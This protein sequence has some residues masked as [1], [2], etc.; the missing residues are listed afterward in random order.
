MPREIYHFPV[1][2][3]STSFL[4]DKSAQVCALE[5]KIKYTISLYDLSLP[6]LLATRLIII[7]VQ[8]QHDEIKENQ[9]F[10]FKEKGSKELEDLAN[11]CQQDLRL[12]PKGN[13]SS[14]VI[15]KTE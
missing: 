1:K 6:L 8:T 2:K 9:G 7:R 3:V 4:L 14:Q 15:H 12:D 10:F 11:T 13:E 5:D